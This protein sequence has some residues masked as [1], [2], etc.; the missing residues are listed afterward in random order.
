GL[1][2]NNGKEI[3]TID[4]DRKISADSL[5]LKITDKE[6]ELL[7]R[8]RN[9]ENKV[10]LKGNATFGL[11][12]VTGDNKKFISEKKTSKNEPVL[13]GSDIDKYRYNTPGNYISFDPENFQQV[14]P[15]GIYRAKEKLLYKFISK[16]LV[17]AY[18]DTGILSL[19]SC[20]I[21]IPQLPGLD[22]KYVLAILNSSVAQFYYSKMFGSVKVLRSH[23]E[24]I[25][26]P[27]A[28]K[29]SQR[30]IIKAVDQLIEGG[31]SAKQKSFDEKISRLYGLSTSEYKAL[32]T[33]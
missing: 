24:Q 22:I 32:I 1:V 30:D 18:D 15:E 19:N 17:F 20:N 4:T 21:L 14:A 12:I 25:P 33:S 7:E 9:I 13:K 2:V 29:M 31:G 3:F 10:T 5:S 16:D 26:I 28:D 8:I 23:L 11:G 6:Y 27:V